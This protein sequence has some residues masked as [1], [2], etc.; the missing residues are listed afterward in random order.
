ML[1]G[2][3]RELETDIVAS[4]NT[5]KVKVLRSGDVPM[6]VAVADAQATAAAEA[7]RRADAER[8]SQ[9]QAAQAPPCARRRTDRAQEL[10]RVE[11]EAA[12]RRQLEEKARRA[13]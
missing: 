10:A 13:G 11:A 6:P 7:Q 2:F 8:L 5:L 3:D 4:G 12:A 1:I 9:A